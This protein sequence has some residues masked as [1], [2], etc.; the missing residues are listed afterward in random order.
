M[1]RLRLH[2]STLRGG[3]V[4]LAVFL[5]GLLL[6]G[7]A[8]VSRPP[9]EAKANPQAGFFPRGQ[10]V[11]FYITGANYAADE[12]PAACT[13]GYHMASLWEILDV[14]GLAYD[15]DHPEAHTQSDSGSGPPS[16][17]YGWVRTGW[18]SSGANTAG[19]ANC[20]AWSV[21]GSGGYGS[22]VRLARSWESNSKDLFSWDAS[23]LQCSNSA[24]VWCVGEFHEVLLPLVTK[25]N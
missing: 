1:M 4:L 12:A 5:A 16:Y 8:L 25:S 3:F 14:T 20:E 17:W 13:A 24:P 23:T 10:G 15:R 7:A 19:M 2:F 21:V 22:I 18:D 6:A 11:H 9:L